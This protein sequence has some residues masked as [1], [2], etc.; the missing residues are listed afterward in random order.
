[1]RDFRNAKVMAQ[2]LRAALSRDGTKIT[3][4]QS[5]EPVAK[6]FG[7]TDWNTLAATIRT[8]ETPIGHK[9]KYH[10]PLAIVGSSPALPFSATLEATLQR[11][12]GFAAQR[13]HEYAT[14][15]YLLLALIEDADAYAALRV[16]NADL[17]REA[18]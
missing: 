3:V 17:S 8:R 15:E 7:V 14:L 4:S 5:L 16:C 13:E 12:L 10:M 2:T 9:D 1:M 18:G 11:A 6:M